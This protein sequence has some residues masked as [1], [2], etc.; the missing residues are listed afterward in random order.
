MNSLNK[1]FFLLILF[2]FQNNSFA[3]PIKNIDITGNKRISDE[4][5]IVFSSLKIN[6]NLEPEDINDLLKRLYETNFFEN[7][8]ISFVDQSLK[9]IVKEYPIIEKIS[10]NGIKS[11]TLKN[12][13]LNNLRLRDR[14][15][16]N[17]ILAQD[18][19][20]QILELL[21]NE[22]YLFSTIDILKT[23][24]LDNKIN[25]EY[26]INLNNKGKVKKITFLGDKIF[27]DK[28][29]RNVIVSEEYKYFKFI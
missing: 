19:K 21:R 7:I 25:L 17:E 18:D 9:I 24:F 10:Y 20:K 23:E 14:S 29:L 26:L 3:I 11:K 13:V 22:G 12:K 8:E 2:F 28:E 4:T 6:D 15:S 5:I 27:K 1:F 16:Y